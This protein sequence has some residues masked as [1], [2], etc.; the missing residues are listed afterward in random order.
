MAYC[1]CP[2]FANVSNVWWWCNAEAVQFDMG[3]RYLPVREFSIA[4]KYLEKGVHTACRT[5]ITCQ[6]MRLFIV[7]KL[8][9]TKVM[10]RRMLLNVRL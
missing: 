8:T 9:V 5:K 7:W 4:F 1:P 10:W 3:M 6:V 2:M